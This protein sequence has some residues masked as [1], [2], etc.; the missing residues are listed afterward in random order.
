MMRIMPYAA[1]QFMTH[2]QLTRSL[3]K[4]GHRDLDPIPRFFAGAAAGAAAATTT[5]PLDLIRARMA[6]QI[7]TKCTYKNIFHGIKLMYAAV[8][9]RG[10]YRG[11]VPTLIG[12]IPYSGVSFFTFDTLKKLIRDSTGQHEVTTFQKLACGAFAG[13]AGQTTTYP[14]EIVRRRMQTDGFLS[15]SGRENPPPRALYIIK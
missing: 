11:I 5:Y 14:L 4:P 9:V 3:K 2:D 7:G 10:L 8:G 1:I 15:P 12:I 6:L 13:L